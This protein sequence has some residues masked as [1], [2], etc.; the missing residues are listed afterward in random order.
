MSLLLVHLI[1][2]QTV[3]ILLTGGYSRVA[4][5]LNLFHHILW[6]FLFSCFFLIREKNKEFNVRPNCSLWQLMSFNHPVY[7]FLVWGLIATVWLSFRGI[8]FCSKAWP[9]WSF[10]SSCYGHKSESIVRLFQQL[11]L[12]EL[13]DRNWMDYDECVMKYHWSQEGEAFLFQLWP[14]FSLL[15][16]ALTNSVGSCFPGDAAF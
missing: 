3:F 13:N 8:V 15:S 16:P 5:K 14:F 10:V 6:Y 9:W 11:C 1:L 2:Y 4:N 7:S 12:H